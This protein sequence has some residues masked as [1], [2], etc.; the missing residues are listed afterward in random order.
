MVAEQALERI[1]FLYIIVGEVICIEQRP[2][3]ALD[4]KVL[5]RNARHGYG[6]CYL[7]PL[8]VNFCFY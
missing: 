6:T 7:Q 3:A 1:S 8:T 5:G 4:A 2:T